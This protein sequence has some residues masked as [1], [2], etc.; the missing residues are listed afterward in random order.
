MIIKPD[1]T[2]TDKVV[3]TDPGVQVP[4]FREKPK[5]VIKTAALI[6]LDQRLI[7]TA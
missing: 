4:T 2:L 5:G 7:I 6:H 3:F 1:P